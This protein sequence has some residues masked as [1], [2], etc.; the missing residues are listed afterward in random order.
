MQNLVGTTKQIMSRLAG[1]NVLIRRTIA[2]WRLRHYLGEI[3]WLNSQ[4]TGLPVDRD[5]NPLPWLTY[6]AISFLEERL[7]KEMRVFEYGSGNS[8]FWWSQRVSSVMSCEHNLNWYK[9]MQP[10][11]PPNVEYIYS[12]LT[13]GGEYSKVISRYK[14]IFD[15]VV[16]DGRDRINCARNAV[17]AMKEDGVIIWDN[18]DRNQYAEGYAHLAGNSFRRLDFRGLGPINTGEWCT[19]IFYRRDNCLAI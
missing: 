18:S 8:T 3:G 19:S 2:L 14:T 12:A 10:R 1:G 13:Y 7:R 11:I 4:R 16:I 9:S 15:I 17:T 6:P 5:G